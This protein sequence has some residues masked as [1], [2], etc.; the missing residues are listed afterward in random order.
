M[1][2]FTRKQK[3]IIQDIVVAFINT[4][5]MPNRKVFRAEHAEYLDDIDLLEKT[6]AFQTDGDKYKIP[7]EFF[8][9][10]DSWPKERRIANKILKRLRE[11]YLSNPLAEFPIEAVIPK[12][13]IALQPS[14]VN[15]ALHYL[16]EVGLISGS[17][18][19]SKGNYLAIS[20]HENVLRYEDI[21]KK[22]S[23]ADKSGQ[24]QLP[25]QGGK[26]LQQVSE[27]QKNWRTIGELGE[28]GQGK[29]SL[30][31]KLGYHNE[32]VNKVVGSIRRLVTAEKAE[33]INETAYSLPLFF[34]EF[35]NDLKE[36]KYRGALK[37]LHASENADYRKALERMEIEIAGMEKISH[38]NIVKILDKN[39]NDGWFVMEY[40]EHGTL[41]KHLPIFKGDVLRSLYAFRKLVEAVAAMH[42]QKLVHRD[43]KPQ[44]IYLKAPGDLVLGDLG[45]IFMQ[46]ADKTRISEAYENVGS[47]DWMPGWAQGKKIEQINPSFDVYCLAKVLW[48]MISGK[49]KL[50]FWYYYLKENDLEQ[51]FPSKEEMPL[52]NKLFSQC[53]V[54]FEKDIKIK[55]AAEL[56]A[57]IDKTIMQVGIKVQRLAGNTARRCLVCGAGIYQLVVNGNPTAAENFGITPHGNSGFKVYTCNNCGHVQLFHFQDVNKPMPAWEK[58]TLEPKI[59]R[60]RG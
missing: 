24:E 55:N 15:R 53:I 48:A 52:I 5:V 37:Q 59:Y 30:V 41:D 25:V 33:I 16:R 1:T 13:E 49:T 43:I 11:L 14:G 22:I 20:P 34:S 3:E 31:E 19:D 18:Q 44:N 58:D 47:R 50:H 35:M 8:K 23:V 42:A 26:P 57:E 9:N 60:Q 4:G 32:V 12:E 28:G 45:L 56:L 17:H 38:P 10:T 46:E 39:L 2:E 54:E 51:L 27:K 36:N 21:D 6:S 7:L 40:F 29:V